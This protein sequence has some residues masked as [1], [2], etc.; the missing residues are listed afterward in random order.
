MPDFEFDAEKS[1]AENI[2]AFHAHLAKEN[3]EFAQLL[4][5]ELPAL[6]PLPQQAAQRTARRAAFNQVVVQHLDEVQQEEAECL[7]TS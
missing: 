1:M 6:V 7:A 4:S 2:A 3:P 5:A